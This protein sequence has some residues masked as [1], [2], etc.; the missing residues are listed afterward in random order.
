MGSKEVTGGCSSFS[1]ETGSRSGNR[2]VKRLPYELALNVPTTHEIDFLIPVEGLTPE[3]VSD[4]KLA[5]DPVLGKLTR[6]PGNGASIGGMKVAAEN[7]W[8]AARPSGTKDVYKLY[9][10][11]FKS[12]SHLESIIE[13]AQKIINRVILGQLRVNRSCGGV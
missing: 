9:A 10:E 4:A 12:R 8:F 5:G 6:A 2:E 11:S 1:R 7:G 3:V 13:E